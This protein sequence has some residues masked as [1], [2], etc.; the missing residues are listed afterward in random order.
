MDGLGSDGLG[1]PMI[2]HLAYVYAAPAFRGVRALAA[3]ALQGEAADVRAERRTR[4]RTTTTT[5]RRRPPR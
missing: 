2:A 4:P 3:H 1:G 5:T